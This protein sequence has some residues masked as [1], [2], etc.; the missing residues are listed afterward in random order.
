MKTGRERQTDLRH[1]EHE[2]HEKRPERRKVF[3]FMSLQ[4]KILLPSIL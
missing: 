4:S 3:P 2:R 1:E